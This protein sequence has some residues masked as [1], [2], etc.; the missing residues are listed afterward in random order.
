M[1]GFFPLYDSR[2]MTGDEN[3]EDVKQQM[4]SEWEHKVD[5]KPPED[6]QGALMILSFDNIEM[7]FIP[8]W[9]QHTVT[10]TQ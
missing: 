9:P 3:T 7:I 6:H 5:L 2:G 10:G 1:L 4:D 8:I